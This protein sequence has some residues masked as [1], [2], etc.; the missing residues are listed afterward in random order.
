[1]FLVDKVYSTRKDEKQI[2]GEVK[3]I[4]SS[5]SRGTARTKCDSAGSTHV[6]RIFLGTRVTQ[7]TLTAVFHTVVPS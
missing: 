6:T 3:S 5:V 7:Y 1:M 4:L 2:G